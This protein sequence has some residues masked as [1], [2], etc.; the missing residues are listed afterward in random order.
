MSCVSLA[1]LLCVLVGCAAGENAPACLLQSTFSSGDIEVDEAASMPRAA[2]QTALFEAESFETE[3]MN[4]LRQRSMA[5]TKSCKAYLGLLRRSFAGL[6]LSRNTSNQQLDKLVDGFI[7]QQSGSQDSCASQLME[8]KHQLN[9]IHQ[10]VTDL[11]VQVNATERAIMALDKEMAAKLKEMKEN[12]EWRVAKLGE[13]QAARDDAAA[14]FGKLSDEMKEMKQIASPGV[15]MDVASGTISGAGD[16]A[17]A[18]PALVQTALDSAPVTAAQ[19]K[20]NGTGNP[21]QDLQQL[22]SFIANTKS[23]ATKYASCISSDKQVKKQEPAAAGNSSSPEK[24]AEEKAMLEKVYVKTYVELSRLKAEYS[25]MANSTACDDAVEAQYGSVKVP[26]QEDIDLLIKAI[27]KKVRA[28]QGLRPRLENAIDAEKKLRKQIQ[29]LT[30]ECAELPATVS[31][32]D[33]VRDAIAALSRCPGLSRVQFSLPK[34]TGT[35]VQVELDASKQTDEQQ[36]NLMD[37]ACDKSASG[38]RAAEVGELEEQTILGMP[39]KNEADE[40][41][42]GACPNCEGDEGAS[43]KSKH[44]R[45]CWDSGSGLNHQEK[46]N[47][48]NKGLKAV[49]CVAD[50]PNIRNIP[51]EDK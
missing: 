22:Q 10:Y 13:C 3:N 21:A 15:S 45:V 32:L 51:G 19:K 28:L 33:K 1:S 16:Q 20:G 24:C 29:S 14:M 11:G 23:A 40:P 42:M 50:R 12:D 17:S 35:W 34:W 37:A 38:T 30:E 9:Q 26:L 31:D 8:A 46:N 47:N 41:L 43:F 27:D 18:K 44:G 48:C 36:D 49:M 25:D 39:V 2:R 5:R 6:E 4:A 7:S